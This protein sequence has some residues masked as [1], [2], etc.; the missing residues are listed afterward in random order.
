MNQGVNH[1]R[2]IMDE[3]EYY[4]I[5]NHSE[6]K[7]IRILKH[8]IDVV[9]EKWKLAYKEFDLHSELWC[10]LASNGIDRRYFKT[11]HV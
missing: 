3:V 7:A 1:Y 2:I 5:T 11:I 4:L 6:E 9:N 8:C 10:E